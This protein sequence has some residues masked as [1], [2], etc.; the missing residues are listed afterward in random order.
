MTSKLLDCVV[1]RSVQESA[2]TSWQ[3]APV[4]PEGLLSRLNIDPD[5]E[6]NVTFDRHSRVPQLNQK[7]VRS[8]H[9]SQRIERDFCDLKQSALTFRASVLQQPCLVAPPVIPYHHH[10]QSSKANY[11]IGSSIDIVSER[12]SSLYHNCVTCAFHGENIW[13]ALA[14]IPLNVCWESKQR[15]TLCR[16]LPAVS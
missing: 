7:S 15:T 9:A 4:L 8:C 5:R 10:M 1:L 14:K 6:G 11:N 3:W 16:A 13:S 12:K 2:R